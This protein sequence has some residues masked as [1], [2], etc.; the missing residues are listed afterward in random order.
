MLEYSLANA[1]F[2]FIFTLYNVSVSIYDLLIITSVYV[3]QDP[4]VLDSMLPYYVTQYGNPH[5]RTHQYGWESEAAVERA[6]KVVMWLL[7]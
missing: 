5:S 7:Y 3:L 2:K 6:R 4:R 1:H